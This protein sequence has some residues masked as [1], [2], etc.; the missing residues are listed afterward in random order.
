MSPSARRRWK[1]WRHTMC[2]SGRRRL[3][4]E[5]WQTQLRGQAITHVA[6]RA[7]ANLIEP[8]ALALHFP[9]ALRGQAI[10]A[11]TIEDD[12][13]RQ[14][15]DDERAIVQ[16][17]IQQMTL[18]LENQRLTD[19]AQQ[20]SQRDRAIAEAADKIHRPSDLDS[21][22]QVAVEEISRIVGT[23]DVRIRVGTIEST[24]GNGSNTL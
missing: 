20:S 12:Q 1:H 3:T 9:I 24:N 18:A 5:A 4:G 16:G 22:L 14:L 7:G 11:V 13:P 2:N 6:Q 17:V 19:V 15:T 8:A 21:I 10:G 23:S